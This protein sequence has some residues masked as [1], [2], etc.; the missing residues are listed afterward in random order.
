MNQL[1]LNL[2]NEA[3]TLAVGEH[4]AHGDL[5]GMYMALEGSLG[6]GKTTLVRGML[7]RL[8]YDGV[9]PSPSYSLVQT[10]ED[11]DPPVYH[12]DC[13]RIKNPVELFNI[14]IEDFFSQSTLVLVEWPELAGDV[15]P[16]PDL[17]CVFSPL[18]QGRMLTLVANSQ[19]GND[20]LQSI[21]AEGY[22]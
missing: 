8:G 14:G 5:S 1:T 11:L 18:T 20:L 15:L 16:K 22:E 13:Y 3:A 9:V 12:I 19:T 10:Y 21:P 2:V 17:R 7:R 4:L 6:L